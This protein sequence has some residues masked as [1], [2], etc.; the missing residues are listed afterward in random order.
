MSRGGTRRWYSSLE[1]T[2]ERKLRVQG[3]C[4]VDLVSSQLFNGNYYNIVVYN[5]GF[6]IIHVRHDCKGN[7][8]VIIALHIYFFNWIKLS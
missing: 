1:K 5:K 4:K 3:C 2:C 7:Y 6:C 8:V